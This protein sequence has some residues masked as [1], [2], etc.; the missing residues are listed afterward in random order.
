[1]EKSKNI[2]IVRSIALLLVLFYH[3]WVKCGSFLI[4]NTWLNLVM[5]LGGELGVTL[6]FVLSGYGI[7]Y[8]VSSMESEGK[9]SFKSFM[10]RRLNRLGPHYYLNLLVLLLLTKNAG[11]ITMSQAP[12]IIMHALFIHN[13]VPR[14]AGAING[15]LWAMGVIVQFYV[16]AIPL[17]ICIQ[18]SKGAFVP[19]AIAFTIFSKYLVFKFIY[20]NEAYLSGVFW[21]SRQLLFTT[22]DNFVIGMGSAYFI[23]NFKGIKNKWAAAAG[24]VISCMLVLLLCK[25]GN[26][27]GIH[28]N[29]LSGY[30]WH[31][32]I[33]VAFG[34]ILYFAYYIRGKNANP[35]SRFLLYISKYEYGIYL[36]HLV[37]ID[38]LLIYSPM[39]SGM[40]SSGSYAKAVIELAIVSVLTGVIFSWL[41]DVYWAEALQRKNL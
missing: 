36:W 30:V 28:T 24:C 8:S 1:M 16:V 6:F 35:V 34:L 23:D 31:S 32:G 39:F 18:K 27:Y 3:I 40:V 13:L 19:A 37:L 20:G 41:V 10:I 29:N 14:Y 21:G 33:A 2:D 12:N 22:L 26:T 9:L 11:Y 15:V 17:Y 4:S 5:M 38:N 7:Y 25:L